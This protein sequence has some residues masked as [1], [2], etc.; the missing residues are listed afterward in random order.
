MY[1]PVDEQSSRFELHN[2]EN[3]NTIKHHY[4]K[5]D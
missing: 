4:L 1:F 5:N 2:L 3:N